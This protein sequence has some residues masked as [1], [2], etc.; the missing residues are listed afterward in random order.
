M[1]QCGDVGGKVGMRVLVSDYAGHPF[2]AQLSRA[3]A[4]S[5]HQ[6]LHVSFEGLQTPKGTLG[7][8]ASD[9]SSFRSVGISTRKPFA[10]QSFFK[11]RLQEIEA[12]HL[13]AR[14][15]AAFQPD[16]V[17]SGNAPL[18][19]QKRI[20]RA[21]QAAGARF[22]FWVQDLYAEAMLRILGPKFGLVGEAVGRLYQRLERRMIRA[23][24]HVVV[25][26][27]EF[28]SAVLE[29]T[30]IGNDRITVIENWAP[31]DEVPKHERGNSWAEANLPASQFRAVYSGTL[32]HK[33]NPELLAKLARALDGDV[34]VFSE[35]PAAE[36]LKRQGAQEGLSNLH[37]S[38]WLPFEILPQALAGADLL[39]VI[40]E[41][42]AGAF[43]V[44]SKV[45]TYMCAGRPIL[46]SVP[47]ENLAARII[48][49]NGA[50]VVVAPADEDGFVAAAQRLTADVEDRRRKGDA[51]RLYA[52]KTFDIDAISKKFEA[53]F[54][55]L[56]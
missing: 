49:A 42:D 13:I 56:T 52:E 16:I 48:E 39:L 17:I 23:S 45:L 28:R 44:P 14:Q 21:A 10:K 30:G 46:G 3:L 4:A 7:V 11:R 40:L 53:I 27:P 51:A 33:H 32:G 31:L 41:P 38:G 54:L 50:G 35:G 43:S 20:Q 2:Q 36:R 34:I 19:T 22:I 55:G 12:G 25:I 15:V 18:D 26:A 29:M 8:G 37:V 5:G 47:G 6:V 9:P 24:D 1:G